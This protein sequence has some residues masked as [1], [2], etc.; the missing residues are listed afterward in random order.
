MSNLKKRLSQEQAMNSPTGRITRPPET[1]RYEL[2]LKAI[3]HGSRFNFV[4]MGRRCGRTKARYLL[5]ADT[6]KQA[7]AK[8]QT[9]SLIQ[10][11]YAELEARVME[12]FIKNNP[13][14]RIGINEMYGI[15]ING[16]LNGHFS[17]DEPPRSERLTAKIERTS[18]GGGS[19]NSADCPKCDKTI[20]IGRELN[21]MT[22]MCKKCGCVFNLEMY[23][24]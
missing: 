5:Q 22:A 6:K 12:D 19:F 7:D 14:K 20:I 24:K 10:M 17:L 23:D 11:N 1:I 15:N 3:S 8:K 13:N 16:T 2:L 21:T 9:N 4:S 18:C